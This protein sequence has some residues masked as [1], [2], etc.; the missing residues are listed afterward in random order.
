MLED[1][2]GVPFALP[3]EAD[4]RFLELVSALLVVILFDIDDDSS[5]VEDPD[6]RPPSFNL[7]SVFDLSAS[8]IGASLPL[9]EAPICCRLAAIRDWLLETLDSFPASARPN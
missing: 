2:K 6:V 3:F 4:F 8:V 5:G 9:F 7:V 1:V